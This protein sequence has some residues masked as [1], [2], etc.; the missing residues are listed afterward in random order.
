MRNKVI[1]MGHYDLTDQLWMMLCKSPM[2]V[3][4]YTTVDSA[5]LQEHRVITNDD[6]GYLALGWP[7]EDHEFL[8]VSI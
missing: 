8:V 2:V 1:A 3:K 5:I 7:L 6:D 4:P